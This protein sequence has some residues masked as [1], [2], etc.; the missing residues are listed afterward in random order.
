MQFFLMRVC[1]DI[2]VSKRLSVCIRYVKQGQAIT[3]FLASAEIPDGGAYTVGEEVY[4]IITNLGLDLTKC[5]SLATDGASVMVGRKT[6][7]GVQ[8]SLNSV[9]LLHKLI[10]LHTGL[11]LP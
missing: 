1:T 7:V 5:V 2:S 3:S 8:L 10:V 11:I 4:K 6:G 9:L